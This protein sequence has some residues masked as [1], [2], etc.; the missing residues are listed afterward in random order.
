MDSYVITIFLVAWLLSEYAHDIRDGR[1]DALH[2][3]V[4][5]TLTAIVAGLVSYVWSRKSAA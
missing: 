2:R 3:L 4:I 5:H 1:A